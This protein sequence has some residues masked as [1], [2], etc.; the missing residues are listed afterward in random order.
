MIIHT[1]VT[2]IHTV[3][4]SQ[5]QAS[6]PS[7]VLLGKGFISGRSSFEGG[8]CCNQG[9][10][11]QVTVLGLKAIQADFF[12]GSYQPGQCSA[13]LPVVLAHQLARV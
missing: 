8:P 11:D 3:V 5:R 1:E 13:N 2:V 4:P 9:L 10:L 6:E 12:Q 7:S